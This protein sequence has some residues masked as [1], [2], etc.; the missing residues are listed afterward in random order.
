MTKNVLFVLLLLFSIN[1]SAKPKGKVWTTYESA[2]AEDPDFMIQGEYGSG[3]DGLGVQV[4]AL[5]SGK[6]DAYF[7][8]GGLPG[9][10]W[11]K[12]K[13]RIKV[14]G[15]TKFEGNGIK[16]EIK[17]YAISLTW[18][19]KKAVLKRV[20]RESPTLG[21][22]APEGAIVLFDGSSADAWKN[23]RLENGL[24]LH[25]TTSKE[26]FQSYKLHI[27]F[28][29]PYRPFDRG[30]GR[31]NSGVYH[32]GRYETQVLDSFGLEGKWNE[33]GGIYSVSEPIL[34]M[35]FP[36]L[37]WQT[38][39][40]ELTSAVYEDGKLVKNPV[41]TVKLNGVLIQKDVELPKHT[42][43]APVK[44]GPEPGPIYLQNHGNPVFYK[45]IWIIKK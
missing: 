37:R 27:E 24:L 2:K 28:M 15:T 31:G 3:S 17:D 4:V 44:A 35:C 40:V 9:D 23:G 21:Q 12:S 22:K 39:D 18:G 14:H 41:I 16:A 11:D 13:K 6:F 8:E 1:L 43:A 42:T 20:E 30:Q 36:P 45:N 10:G 38:Y 25:G 29:T 26:K 33:T 19:D 7:L 32:Q 5:G 34:N